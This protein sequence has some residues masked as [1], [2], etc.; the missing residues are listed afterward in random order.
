[1]T[2]QKD[3]YSEESM[4]FTYS[5]EEQEQNQ[6]NRENAERV[7][8]PEFIPYYPAIAKQY[9]LSSTEALLYGFIRFYMHD[10]NKGGRF[11]FTD[12]Q[13]AIILNSSTPTISRAMR[14]LRECGLVATSKAIKAGGG[15]IRFVRT[16]QADGS[17]Q[18]KM[19]SHI[20][21]SDWE[22]DN[23]INKNKINKY[24]CSFELFWSKYPK[25]VSKRKSEE[26]YT[27]L[28]T[29]EEVEQSLLKGLDSYK[30]K[31]RI[32]CT[33]VKYIPNP[34]TWLNQARWEDEVMISNEPYK[35]NARE[36][37]NHWEQVKSAEKKA[38]QD[39]LIDDGHGRPIK[40]SDIL[41]EEKS[42][43]SA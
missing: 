13:L 26:I 42:L 30:E 23:K 40:L 22:I 14:K 17:D 29:S 1:M 2:T 12:E 24:I 8:S 4:L 21:Q 11:Y 34:T 28:A 6:I 39:V 31:W 33:D 43:Q 15:T 18:S 35:K 41:N 3:G 37:E 16:I 20:N 36:F 5:D 27:K 32:E 10:A 9:G 7:F 38:Y 25:K 19:T